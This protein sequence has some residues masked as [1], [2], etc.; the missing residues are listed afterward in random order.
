ML[1]AVRRTLTYGQPQFT[2]EQQR[3]YFN[4]NLKGTYNFE[5]SQKL[6]DLEELMSKIEEFV[7]VISK[8]IFA[9]NL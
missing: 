8:A 9:G 5:L 6:P 2:V 3:Y 1:D 4:I 7:P